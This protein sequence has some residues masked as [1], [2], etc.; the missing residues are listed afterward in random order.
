MAFTV[1][2]AQD[3]LR[4]YDKLNGSARA[5]AVYLKIIN[6]SCRE[7]YSLGEPDYAMRTTRV[8]LA[9]PYETGTVSVSAGGT[10]VT[11]SGTTF[12]SGMAG[13]YI[14]FNGEAEQ[15]LITAFGS[16]TSLTIETYLGPS[17]LTDVTYSITEDRKS[18]PTL[19]RSIHEIVL[20]NASGARGSLYYLKPRTFEAL[21]FMRQSYETATYPYFFATKWEAPTSGNVPVGYVYLFPNPVQ[22]QIVTIHYKVWPTEVST[23]SDQCPIPYDMEAT[24]RE[25]LLAFLYRENRDP[26]WTVQLDRARKIGL[27]SI[28]TSRTNTAHRRRSEWMPSYGGDDGWREPVIDPSV[29]SQI[30]P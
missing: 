24:L 19:C 26:N 12:T 27:D 1:T 10:T 3:F 28:G 9:A 7:V 8:S 4:N 18:L 22:A 21:N 6:D 5:A 25:F 11:G 15:Y 17:N 30:D 2:Q 13:R 14:R 29:L 16:T 20:A 23:G